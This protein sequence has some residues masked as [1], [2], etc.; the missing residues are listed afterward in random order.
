[1][2]RR[3]RGLRRRP[4]PSYDT[5]VIGGGIGGLVAG[6]LLAREGQKVL[7]VEQHYMLGG[8]CSTFRRGGFTFEAATHFYP[9]LGNPESWPGRLMRDL[10]VTTEWIQMDPVDTFHLPDGSRFDVPA[11][12]ATYRQRLDER[13]PAE[14]DA[15]DRFFVEVRDAYLLGLLYYFRGRRTRRFTGYEPQ[16][17]R[18]ALDRHFKDE[19]LKLLLTADC[20]HWGG[21]PER[22]SFVFDSMLRLS[23]FLGNYFPKGGSQ[24]FADELARCFEAAGGEVLMS[25]EVDRIEVRDGRVAGVELQTHRGGLR[26]RYSVAADVVV[27]NADLRLTVDRLLPGGSVDPAYR[28]QVASLRPSA[29]CFLTHIGV[30]GVDRDALE[31]AQGYYWRHW[32]PDRLGRDGLVCKVFVPTLYD[33]SLAP[34]GGDIVILQKVQELDYAAVEDWTTHKLAVEEEIFRHLTEVVP[35]LRERTAVRLSASAHTSW[36]FTWNDAGAM[37]GWEMSPD[38][39]GENRPAVE[40]PV[41]GLYLVGHWTR[42]GGGIVPVLVSAL[43]VAARL[44]ASPPDLS[45]QAP[46]LERMAG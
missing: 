41:D 44:G 25:T 28:A 9:L 10:G 30:H 34:P 27:S 2:K 14:R 7:L 20:P 4:G 35:G 17:V 6:L 18:D 1:M 8:Y 12:Y 33:P 5:V 11:D 16:T 43:D 32:D 24:A 36:R 45:M 15:L 22:T 40:G 19:A 29:P 26:G 37:L 38:Q 39:L 42:P 21:P 23:Y 31:R 13:F 46:T 3:F